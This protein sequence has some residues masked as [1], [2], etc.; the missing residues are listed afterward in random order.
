MNI[1][2][3]NSSIYNITFCIADFGRSK[4][5]LGFPEFHGNINKMMLLFLIA[6]LSVVFEVESAPIVAALVNRWVETP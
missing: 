3:Y 2:I 4:E 1:A 6:N 5:P